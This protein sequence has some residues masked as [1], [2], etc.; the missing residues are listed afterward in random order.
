MHLHFCTCSMQNVTSKA[1]L[2]PQKTHLL[3]NSDYL[4]LSPTISDSPTS[5]SKSVVTTSSRCAAKAARKHTLPHQTKVVKLPSW[6]VRPQEGRM[7]LVPSGFVRRPFPSESLD[8]SQS[9]WWDPNA[10]WGPR[11]TPHMESLLHS[12]LFERETVEQFQSS[13][14]IQLHT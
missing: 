3:S 9:S 5:L 7:W 4:R 11:A 13:N 10:A 2:H 14:Y 12:P 1:S 6:R 8:K